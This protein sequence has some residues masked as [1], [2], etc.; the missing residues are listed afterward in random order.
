MTPLNDEDRIRELEN[1]CAERGAVLEN[2]TK[3]EENLWLAINELRGTIGE[4]RD[5]INSAMVKIGF[6]FGGA[7]VASNLVGWLILMGD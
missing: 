6:I 4:L 7:V 2:L 3:Q 5:V 1:K